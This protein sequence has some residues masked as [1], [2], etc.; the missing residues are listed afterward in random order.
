MLSFKDYIDSINE[1]LIKTYPGDIIL[2]NLL[3]SLMDLHLDVKGTFSNNKICLTINNFNLIPLN[4]LGII[5]NQIEIIAINNGGWFPSI[6]E[7]IKLTSIKKI[8]KFKLKDIIQI[9]DELKK[10]II[11]FESKYDNII[12][13]IPDKLY[14]LTIKEYSS[15]INKK[16]LI[17]RSKSKLSSHLDRIYVCYTIQ[18]CIDLIPK[19]MFYYTGEKDENIYKLGKNFFKK[20]ITPIIYEID[21]SDKNINKLY[22]DINYEQ[23]GY[24]TLNNIPPSKIKQ[25]KF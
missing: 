1:G 2:K 24:Y 11:I 22:V 23:K 8:D 9:H 5:F 18:N 16:G 12:Y 7:L 4:K 21:N 6:M 14:H 13:D 25:I 19:M 3:S 15:K 10:V 17:P 20:D